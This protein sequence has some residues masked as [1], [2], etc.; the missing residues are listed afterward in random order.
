V[1]YLQAYCANCNTVLNWPSAQTPPPNQQYPY[2]P[3]QQWNQQQQSYQT[4]AGNQQAGYG[5]QAQNRQ[6]NEDDEPGFLQRIQKHKG[7]IA[8]I[9]IGLVIAA[10]LIGGGMSMKL[11]KLLSAPEVLSFDTSATE[12]IAG[13]EATLQWDVTGASSVSITPGIGV[14]QASGIRKVS[15]E[16]TTTYAL[17]ASNFLGSASRTK[18]ITVT[19][20]PPTIDSFNFNTGN[21]N[22]GQSA[23]LSWNVTGSTSVAISPDIGPVEPNGTHNLSPS[24]TTTYTLTASNGAGNSTASATITVAVSNQPIIT[25][26]SASPPAIKSGE[27][28][29]LTWSVIGATSININEG[30]GGVSVADSR[31]VT[32]L[33]TTTYKLTAINNYGSITKSV[34]VTVDTSNVTATENSTTTTTK[35]VI[36]SFSASSNNITLGDN[37]TLT[38]SVSGARNITISQGIGSVTASGSISVYPTDNTTYT[39]TAINSFGSENATATIT[40]NRTTAT[41]VFPPVINSFTATPDTI[42]PGGS[43]N[44][45]WDISGATSVT[46]DQG[47]GTPSTFGQMVYPTENTTYTLTAINPAGT[48]NATV[49]ITVIQ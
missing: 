34:T 44:L 46:I 14:V 9:V 32:P 20:A 21:I 4:P 3:Q 42:S 45:T 49:T 13:Q 39:L 12:I 25:T 35:P 31:N 48:D 26:F 36:S 28:T 23:T 27:T 37:S 7:T 41:D 40:V 11:D 16:T 47:I 30:I 33:A 2:Q 24:S 22:A 6:Q 18:T 19:G 15:P 8:K 17:L 5:N 1:A 43:S 10:V 38:W 29:T